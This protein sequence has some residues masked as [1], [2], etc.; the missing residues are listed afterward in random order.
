[1]AE[2][3]TK[4]QTTIQTLLGGMDQ[5]VA[6]KTVVGDPVTVGSTSIVPLVDISF[7]IG[8]GATD[9]SG[10][11]GAAGG[12]GGKL[13]PSAVLV[14]SE[15]VSKI[16]PVNQN[17]DAVSKIIDMV[18]ELINKFTGPKSTYDTDPE[19]KEAVDDIL[20]ENE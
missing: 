15:G 4:L 13:K 3:D 17:Q 9:K 2:K 7:G 12:M 1:M 20:S 10:N 14:I 6:A 11:G 18:P 16:I 8:A 5:F 19:V